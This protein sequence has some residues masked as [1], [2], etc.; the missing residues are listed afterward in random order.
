[1]VAYFFRTSAKNI[2][3]WLFNDVAVEYLLGGMT[4]EKETMAVV[5]T[6]ANFRNGL[7]SLLLA[8]DRS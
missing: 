6:P 8:C 4:D 1:L 2:F 3:N 5:Y 7:G